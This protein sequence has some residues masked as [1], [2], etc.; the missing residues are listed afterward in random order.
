M[1]LPRPRFAQGTRPPIPSREI[2]P[3]SAHLQRPED[4][5]IGLLPTAPP[6]WT[7]WTTTSWRHL[8]S[9]RT[10]HSPDH[11]IGPPGV[12][13]RSRGVSTPGSVYTTVFY[14]SI[15][16]DDDPPRARARGGSWG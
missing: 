5:L 15:D 13:G 1:V 2:R 10:G 9:N 12:T 6:R 8:A 14:N 4:I 16:I 7:A 11:R 3:G